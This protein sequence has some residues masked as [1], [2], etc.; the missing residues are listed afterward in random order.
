MEKRRDFRTTIDVRVKL[1]GCVLLAAGVLAVGW[2]L[3]QPSRRPLQSQAV[4]EPVSGAPEQPTPALP[5]AADPRTSESASDSEALTERTLVGTRWEREGFG[6]EFG[7]HGRLFIGGRER[8]QWRVE[9]RRV[10]LYRGTTGEEHWLD[11]V[12]NKLMWEGQQIGRVN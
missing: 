9:G 11:I 4:A 3:S 12:G 1:L 10:R 8:A 7:A 6:I 2:F 5:P